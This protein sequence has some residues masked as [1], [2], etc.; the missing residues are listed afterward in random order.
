M[1][2]KLSEQ[3]KTLIE[4]FKTDSSFLKIFI[5]IIMIVVLVTSLLKMNKKFKKSIFIVSY[6]GVLASIIY[7]YSNKLL[8]LYDYLVEYIVSNILFPNLALYLLML[9]I[10][11]I[12]VIKSVLSNKVKTYIKSIN[13]TGFGIMQIFLYFIVRNIIDNNIN[14]YEKLSVYTNSDLLVLINLSMQSFLIWMGVLLI[15]KLVDYLMTINEN[16]VNNKV[17]DNNLVIEEEQVLE[18]YIPIKKNY[19]TVYNEELGYEELIEFVPIKK[20]NA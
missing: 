7:T 19:E 18:E 16:K 9:L 8:T 1:K 17:I 5:G 20:K 14:V 6:I 13:I 15:I 12:I 3:L 11:N 4:I 10:I 2:M